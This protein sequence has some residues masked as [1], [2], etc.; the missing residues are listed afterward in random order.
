MEKK[1][2][3]SGST[4]K[5]I[6][7][8]AMLIDHIG[9]GV[10]GRYISSTGMPMLDTAEGVRWLSEYGAWMTLYAVMRMIGRLGFPIFCF[11]L[12]E[13]FEHTRDVKKYAARLL[14]FCIIRLIFCFGGRYWNLDIRTFSL[15]CLSVCWSYVSIVMWSSRKN[16]MSYGRLSV[17]LRH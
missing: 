2:G 14:A 9:A 5:I 11:L 16:G 17:I 10:V 12:I 15:L 13:G 1:R 6:A 8:L 7:I 4:I 3:I